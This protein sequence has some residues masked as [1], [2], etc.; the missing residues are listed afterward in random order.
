VLEGLGGGAV[1]QWL[2]NLLW[3]ERVFTDAETRLCKHCRWCQPERRAGLMM[4]SAQ[5]LSPNVCDPDF[6]HGGVRSQ[7]C[8][9]ARREH[10]PCGPEG[11]YWEPK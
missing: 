1:M 7:L 11:K 8:Y 6:V 2:T 4:I 5:C 3:G 10:W 9:S